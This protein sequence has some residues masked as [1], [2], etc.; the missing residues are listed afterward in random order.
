MRYKI[1]G[2]AISACGGF[3]L[4]LSD[5]NVPDNVLLSELDRLYAEWKS[6]DDFYF[7]LKEECETEIPALKA[8]SDEVEFFKCLLGAKYRGVSLLS[9]RDEKRRKESL[10]KNCAW[11]WSKMNGVKGYVVRGIGNYAAQSIFL[12]CAGYGHGTSL[13]NAGSRGHY[14]SSDPY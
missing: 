4:V 12:P 6:E 11:T 1:L 9:A 14:W 5:G 7:F 8:A 2:E 3:K 10:W 13:V